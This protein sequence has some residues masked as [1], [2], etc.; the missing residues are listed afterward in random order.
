MVISFALYKEC[1]ISLIS[2]SRFSDASHAF[3]YVRAIDNFWSICLGVNILRL[4]WPEK[5]V[6]ILRLEWPEKPVPSIFIGNIL[7]S[8][9]LRSLSLSLKRLYKFL[10]TSFSC[11]FL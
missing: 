1:N 8:K 7:L 5:P 10:R 2:L 9:A 11:F 4:E 6:N 3:T